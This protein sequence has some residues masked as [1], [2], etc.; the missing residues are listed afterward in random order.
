MKVFSWTSLLTAGFV[1]YMGYAFHSM[2]KIAVPDIPPIV[3][4]DGSRKPTIGPLWADASSLSFDLLLS[5]KRR[6]GGKG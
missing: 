3:R 6:R 2:Y 5:L 4:P 1:A